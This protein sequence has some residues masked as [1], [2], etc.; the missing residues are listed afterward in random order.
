MAIRGKRHHFY[1]MQVNPA[2][3]F[4]PDG[5]S[6]CQFLA[7]AAASP[8]SAPRMPRSPLSRLGE[9]QGCWQSPHCP[10]LVCTEARRALR[11]LAEWR[12]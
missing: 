11:W 7:A 4:D 1:A 2:D 5:I 12:G 10:S 8:A 9:G 6:C 3:G